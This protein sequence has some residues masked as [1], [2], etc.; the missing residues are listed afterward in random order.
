MLTLS[1]NVITNMVKDNVKAKERDGLVTDQVVAYVTNKSVAT[2]RSYRYGFR[3][4]KV[5]I[6]RTT[7]EIK[8]FLEHLREKN[9]EREVIRAAL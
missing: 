4:D 3:K 6:A 2:I 8:E 1:Y 7:K 9:I 5:G